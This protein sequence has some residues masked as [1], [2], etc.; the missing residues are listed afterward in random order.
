MRNSTKCY[1]VE[2]RWHGDCVCDIAASLG[3]TPQG[4]YKFLA[5]LDSG[6]LPFTPRPAFSDDYAHE[7]LEL[8]FNKASDEEFEAKGAS[9][10]D[11]L[12]LI[13][14]C[15]QPHYKREDKG[16]APRL[17]QWLNENGYTVRM[18]ADISGVDRR[19]LSSVL[20]GNRTLHL[21][22]ANMLA[23]VTGLKVTDIYEGLKPPKQW[24]AC[25]K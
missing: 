2:S 25:I 15:Q 24:E 12:K 5:K 7:V 16:Y 23:I 1:I 10:L 21:A 22:Q 19:L 11:A 17:I 20:C 4:V 9:R 13:K 3:L 8:Y 6:D 18:L 14:F